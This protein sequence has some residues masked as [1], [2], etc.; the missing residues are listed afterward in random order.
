MDKFPLTVLVVEDD[1][2]SRLVIT[3][4]IKSKFQNVI[5][6]EN[7]L[8]GLELFKQHSPDLICIRYWDAIS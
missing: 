2:A 1:L 5:E 7:G 4:I 6:A 8:Q 3:S